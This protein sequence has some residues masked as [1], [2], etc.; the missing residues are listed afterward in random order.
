MPQVR[1][2]HPEHHEPG[3]G[4]GDQGRYGAPQG[5]GYPQGPRG[6]SRPAPAPQGRVPGPR[7]EFIDAFD[8]PAPPYGSG[9][10]T[11]SGTGFGTDADSGQWRPDPYG[12]VT[13]WD[14]KDSHPRTALAADSGRGSDRDG[15]EA[16]PGADGDDGRPAKGGLGRAFTGIA[17][18]A[19]TTVLAVVVAGQVTDGRDSRAD[20]LPSGGL[21]RDG[22]DAASRSDDRQS[23]PKESVAPAPAPPPTYAQLM[24]KQFPLAADLAGPGSSRRSPGSPRRPARARRSRTG[25]TSRRASGSTG[26]CSPTRCRKP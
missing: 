19:V 15:P 18:A 16:A 8:A 11:G 20:A 14:D 21:A 17:A 25:S 3:G 2:G 22:E 5:T 12:P 9:A 1:G 4:W 24:A 10:G 23:A 13:D 7:R 6:R 26:S